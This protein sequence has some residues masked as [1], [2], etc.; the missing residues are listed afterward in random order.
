MAIA[1]KAPHTHSAERRCERKGGDTLLSIYNPGPYYRAHT[2][3]HPLV[4]DGVR[5]R[6]A[7]KGGDE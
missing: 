1:E 2:K 4:G 5:A 6:E 3:R 7:L